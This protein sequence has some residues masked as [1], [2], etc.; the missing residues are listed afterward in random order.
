MTAVAS[1]GSC[2]QIGRHETKKPDL[3]AG[4]AVIFIRDCNFLNGQ[5][6]VTAGF[7]AAPIDVG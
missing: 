5:T 3:S 2:G 1:A 6:G 7:A 4:L